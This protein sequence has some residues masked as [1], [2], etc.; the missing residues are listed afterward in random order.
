[1]VAF[2]VL[3]LPAGEGWEG[4]HCTVKGSGGHAAPQ[5]GMGWL[6]SETQTFFGSQKTS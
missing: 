5:C 4:L 6:P 1:M 2:G 3:A